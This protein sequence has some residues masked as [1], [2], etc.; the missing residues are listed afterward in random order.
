MFGFS[1]QVIDGF[2]FSMVSFCFTILIGFY[3]YRYL[4][5]NLNSELFSAWLSIFEFSQ[6]L[7]LLDLGFTHTF[8]R[9]Y[10]KGFTEDAVLELPFVRG[11][12]F[13]VGLIAFIVIF[14]VAYMSGLIKLVGVLPVI[15]LGVSV[16]VTLLGYADTASLRLKERFR[17]IYTI[18]IFSNFLYVVI[19][20]LFPITLAIYAISAAIFLRSIFLYCLQN[21][22]LGLGVSIKFG[23][24]QKAN[25][26][27]VYLNLSYFCLFMFDAII[28]TFLGV[29][30]LVLGVVII[31]KKYYDILRGLFDSILNVL[32]V[33][34]AKYV[35]KK[36]DFYVLIIAIFIFFT[37]FICSGLFIE[38][39]IENFSFDYN[40]SMT[41][42][43]A[44]LVITVFRVEST[45]IFFHGG[46]LL[47]VLLIILSIKLLFVFS[48][49]LSD[50]DVILS[51]NI[52]SLGL[53]LCLV[54]LFVKKSQ[55]S[56]R[57]E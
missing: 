29:P 52:Q 10:G 48:L 54:W 14:L 25:L 26:D 32:S 37:A 4:W 40:F 35:D 20:L 49:F 11:A 41:I 43:F 1:K 38:L 8:I 16:L 51:Y 2:L 19:L 44:I 53:S 17:L 22:Y 28:M 50:L 9:K 15:S 34:F 36:R 27:V 3:S 42:C 30:S 46:G 21:F 45:K 47:K 24:Y 5:G 7:L 13:I 56:I 33:V 12:L 39:W 31:Y 6:F 55:S 23:G 57:L 18:S